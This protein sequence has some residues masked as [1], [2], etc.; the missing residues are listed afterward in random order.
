MSQVFIDEVECIGCE[1]CVELCPGTFQMDNEGEKAVVINADSTEE[2][3]DEAIDTCPVDCISR[4][5]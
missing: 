2:C 4:E 1:S 3:V 5:G